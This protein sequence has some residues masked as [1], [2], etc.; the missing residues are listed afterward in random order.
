LYYSYFN[1][2]FSYYYIAFLFV[3]KKLKN[4]QISDPKTIDYRRRFI[5]CNLSIQIPPEVAER[6]SKTGSGISKSFTL[7]YDTVYLLALKS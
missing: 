4:W 3:G 2:E 6:S 5:S 1:N 7:R